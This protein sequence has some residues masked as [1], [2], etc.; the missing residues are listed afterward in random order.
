MA[1]K[2]KTEVAP[3]PR[4]RVKKASKPA[5]RKPK[6]ASTTV[7]ARESQTLFAVNEASV[8]IDEPVLEATRAT[9][10]T[11]ELVR[12]APARAELIHIAAAPIAPR[13]HA[14]ALARPAAVLVLVAACAFSVG[15]LRGRRASERAPS[16]VIASAPLASMPT[17]TP[18]PVEPQ[19]FEIE[20]ALGHA[21]FA[22]GRRE[23]ALR[24]YD[25]ALRLDRQAPDAQM[26]QNLI[27]CYGLRQA[28]PVA[29]TLIVRHQL[30][31]AEPALENLRK[32]GATR[33]TRSGALY[34]L[35]KLGRSTRRPS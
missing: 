21:A 2:R 8:L 10:D 5:P 12:D 24:H 6:R 23:E 25:R 11:V 4:S 16:A 14:R 18:Q 33:G 22:A 13:W 32:N 7:L 19:P 1:T 35:E 17:A 9:D 31:D 27:A 20:R 29:A 15:F 34:T 26:T 3:T 28:Q 30:H